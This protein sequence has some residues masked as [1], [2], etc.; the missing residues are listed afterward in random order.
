MK[1]LGFFS[2]VMFVLIL[3]LLFIGFVYIY[4]Y[5]AKKEKLL[6]NQGYQYQKDKKKK[7]LRER[8]IQ[9]LVRWGKKAGPVGIKYPFF[10]DITKH[11]RM[12]KEAGNPLGFHLQDFY[13]FRFVLGLIGLGFGS[14][15]SFL[16]MPWGLQILLISILGGFLGPSAWLYFKA[17]NR[18]E[19]ITIMMPDFLDTVSVT[20][21]A[22]V[23]LDNALQQVT[24]QFEGPLS[25]EIDRF[26]REIDLGVPRISAYQSLMDR[27]SSKEL[28]S[29]VNG[30]IQ[31][32]TLGVP[33]SRTFKLQA[34]D[35]RATRGFVAKEKAA[36]ASPQITL[37]TTFFV[38]PAVFG[39]IIGLL[40]LNIM[41]NPAAFGLDSFF[42]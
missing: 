41:Y 2:L 3:I 7:S 14:F 22:G 16:G 15:Y 9:P 11:E 25:E 35:L 21:Q 39:L 20:L 31:G 36:K 26:N 33:V 13:G 32:S 23:S 27:N 30:L 29:L 6:K 28:H 34:D 10:A 12:L 8:I 38:A 4:L 17:K 42:K 24:Q 19:L 18:Q 40:V 37:V 1:L 5:I